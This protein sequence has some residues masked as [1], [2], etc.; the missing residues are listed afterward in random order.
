MMTNIDYN[1]IFTPELSPKEMLELGVFGGYYFKDDISEFPKSWFKNAKVNTVEFDINMNYFNIKSGLSIDHWIA[2][3][4]IFAEDP[5]GWFQWY[6]RYSMGRRVPEM[7]KIQ[8]MRW[9]AFGPRHKGAIKKNCNNNDYSCRPRQR[10]GLLQWAY[11][12]FF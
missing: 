3:N 8:I 7:D 6:C 1:K 4:W 2:K 10:Q 9:K 5:I 12:P 11:D